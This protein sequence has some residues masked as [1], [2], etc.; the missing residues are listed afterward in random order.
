MPRGA[1]PVALLAEHGVLAAMAEAFEPLAL[2]AEL[3]D[4]AAEVRAL[5]P[6]RH[7]RPLRH[8]KGRIQVRPGIVDRRC[9]RPVALDALLRRRHV[10]DEQVRRAVDV[11][12]PV[13]PLRLGGVDL[14]DRADRDLRAETLAQVRPQER[15]RP[16][17]ELE[18]QEA[19]AHAEHAAHEAA[20]RDLADRR[21]VDLAVGRGLRHRLKKSPSHGQTQF[22]PGPR[23]KEPMKVTIRP[24]IITHRKRTHISLRS[25]AAL[26]GVR[27]TYGISISPPR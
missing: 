8:R 19:D 4:L 24:P 7:H 1:G 16:A 3:R 15:E 20:S 14:V 25:R 18:R 21:P 6:E 13:L 22:Q 27:S 12:Q 17:E 10:D 9:D 2:I 5:A 23:K 26:N 11:G